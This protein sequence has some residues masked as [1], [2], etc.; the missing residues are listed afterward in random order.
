MPHKGEEMSDRVH[1][2]Q[3]RE[4]TVEFCALCPTATRLHIA[5]A[6]SRIPCRVCHKRKRGSRPIRC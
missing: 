4:R 1:T 2:P 5:T 3:T 6:C